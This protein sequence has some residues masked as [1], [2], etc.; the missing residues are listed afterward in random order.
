[1]S[2]TIRAMSACSALLGGRQA[3]EAEG[4]TVGE[5]LEQLNVLD[6]VRDD[7]GGV[8]RHLNISI[9][10]SPDIR[11]LQGLDTPVKDGDVVTLLAALSG[12]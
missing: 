9:N 12:G 3:A 5:A 6:D 1:M 11:F 10:N 7:Q 2:V 8:R 4:R